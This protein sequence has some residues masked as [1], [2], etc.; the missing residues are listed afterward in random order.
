[1]QTIKHLKNNSNFLQNLGVTDD[2][3]NKLTIKEIKHYL[4]L[5]GQNFKNLKEKVP[6]LGKNGKPLRFRVGGRTVLE[7][8]KPIFKDGYVPATG[9]EHL[10]ARPG[11]MQNKTNKKR[12][13]R[14]GMGAMGVLS[15]IGIG[16]Y[17]LL[18]LGQSFGS[19]SSNDS[20]TV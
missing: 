12:H 18:Q 6:I 8:F 9:T 13:Q 11:F 16:V 7:M 2:L 14:G 5:G 3:K 19:S 10:F 17:A 20:Q 4:H 15:L 1:M